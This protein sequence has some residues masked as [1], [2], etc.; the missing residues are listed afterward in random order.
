[1]VAR[2]AVLTRAPMVAQMV[3]R[4]VARTA[5][6]TPAPMVAQMVVRTVAPMVAPGSTHAGS[7]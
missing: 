1:M 4:T 7:R 2:T 5:V 6:L 3:V